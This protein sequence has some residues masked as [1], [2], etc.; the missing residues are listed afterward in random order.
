MKTLICITCYNESPDLLLPSLES[1]CA[2]SAQADIAI[3]FDG[4][5]QIHDDTKRLL[6]IDPANIGAWAPDFLLQSG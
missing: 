4:W 5:A 2:I 1:A 6:N 3:V